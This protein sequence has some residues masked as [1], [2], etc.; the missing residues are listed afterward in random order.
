[1]NKI[2]SLSSPDV[3]ETETIYIYPCVNL[4]VGRR[5]GLL[6]GLRVL[7]GEGG[8]YSVGEKVGRYVGY[9]VVGLEV[10]IRLPL[11]GLR[12]GT[13]ANGSHRGKALQYSMTSLVEVLFHMM[14]PLCPSE[15]YC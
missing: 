5:V 3:T 15:K 1:M 4:T 2:W 7:V 11:A 6:V 13:N 14:L 10:R 9:S 8:K 12:V